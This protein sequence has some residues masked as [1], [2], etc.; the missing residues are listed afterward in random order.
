MHDQRKLNRDMQVQHVVSVRGVAQPGRVLR[1][2]RRSRRFESSHP[3]QSSVEVP[4]YLPGVCVASIVC[5]SSSALIAF[6]S[7]TFT[8]PFRWIALVK[9]GM[10]AHAM[11]RVVG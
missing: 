3:D 7:P 2:G 1:S 9:C 6:L 10:A 4:T 11:C 5:F 8:V